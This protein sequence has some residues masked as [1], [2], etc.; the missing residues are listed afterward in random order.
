MSDYRTSQLER[1]LQRGGPLTL[2]MGCNGEIK[3]KPLTISFDEGSAITEILKPKKV[4]PVVDTTEYFI[5][6]LTEI[7]GEYEY[8]CKV[9]TKI[10]NAQIEL[11]DKIVEIIENFRGDGEWR[12]EDKDHWTT[13]DDLGVKCS[14]SKKITAAEYTVMQAYLSTL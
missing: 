11:D 1:M 10:T 5:L 14:D 6:I 8:D 3:T 7:N 12:D 4:N 9:L 2:T 13:D